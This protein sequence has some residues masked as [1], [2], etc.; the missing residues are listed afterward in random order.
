MNLL[1]FRRLIRPIQNRIYRI[2]GRAI[3]TALDNTGGMQRLK[4]SVMKDETLSNI[5][6]IQEYGLD[7]YPAADTQV[8]L[9]CQNGNREQALAIC[10]SDRDARPT[11][12]AE[13]EVCLYTTED[14]GGDHRIHLKAGKII[15]IKGTTLNITTTG[16]AV[17]TCD[18][19]NITSST[20]VN[21]DGG[22]GSPLGVVQGACACHF[23]GSPH[24]DVSTNV[25]ASK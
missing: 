11:D 21:I 18:T 7:T 14:D 19:A 25:K 16:N 24:G 15:D 22:T 5:E 17:I 20:A 2:I 4:L 12:L 23:T 6:R 3:L 10:V 13:G 1:D 9:V 8:I